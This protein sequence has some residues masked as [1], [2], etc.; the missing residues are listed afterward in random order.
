MVA[1]KINN[2]QTWGKKM[3]KSA[4]NMCVY[5]PYWTSRKAFVAQ[6][7]NNT[8][9]LEAVSI[10]VVNEVVKLLQESKLIFKLARQLWE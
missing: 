8:P 3:G 4:S 10:S 1:T 6:G 2:A 7:E 9:E 5:V